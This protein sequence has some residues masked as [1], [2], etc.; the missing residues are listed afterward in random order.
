MKKKFYILMGASG[1]GK[2]T[3]G[4][5]LKEVFG[6]PEFISHTTRDPR[7]GEVDGFTYYFVDEE[8]FK[9]TPKIEYS[10]YAG[11]HYCLS[12]AEVDRVLALS[13]KAFLIADVHGVEQIRA[14]YKDSDIDVEVIY[15]D[16]TLDFM[17][18]RMNDRGDSQENIQKRLDKT[19]KDK[20]LENGQYADH[21]IPAN[22]TLEELY[23]LVEEIVLK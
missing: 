3:V 16:T 23:S 7:E 13:D 8:T 10:N 11:K 4:N 12:V 21:I 9:D 2:T 20:E 19:V 22:V 17:K 1:A 15:I 18:D 5:R 6:V 14:F